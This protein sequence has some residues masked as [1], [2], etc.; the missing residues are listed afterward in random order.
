MLSEKIQ[1]EKEIV[2]SR[3]YEES[4]KAELIKRD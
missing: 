1:P 2:Q 4:K 3:L